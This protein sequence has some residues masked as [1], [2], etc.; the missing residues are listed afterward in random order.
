[1][2]TDALPDELAIA[3]VNHDT[4]DT[5]WEMPMTTGMES[6][7][8][9]SVDA[10]QLAYESTRFN[11]GMEELFG[12]FDALASAGGTQAF[13]LE[14]VGGEI[15]RRLSAAVLADEPTAE[16]VEFGRYKCRITGVTSTTKVT[17]GS[18]VIQSTDVVHL[19]ATQKIPCRVGESF[20]FKV[21]FKHL[22]RTP[23]YVV[24]TVT[25]HPPITQPNGVVL[26]QSHHEETLKRAK[27][28]YQ[29]LWHFRAGFEYELVPGKWTKTI[30]V[31]GVEVANM[32]FDVVK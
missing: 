29:T 2:V 19:E 7:D 28:R 3:I 25:D 12:R 31:D 17:S 27:A 1:M 22:P 11:A 21:S 8:A 10:P 32:T 26:K 14:T 6:T 23:A 16:V 5:S 15:S 4:T 24:R 13:G 18:V 30:Y 9:V 20:G